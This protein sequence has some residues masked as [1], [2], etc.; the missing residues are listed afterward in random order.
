MIKFKEVEPPN[1]ATR[2]QSSPN[3]EMKN[4]KII[5]KNRKINKKLHHK[6]SD[7]WIISRKCLI[8]FFYI[9]SFFSAHFFLPFFFLFYC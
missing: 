5:V 7:N 8:N 2:M 3:M 1:N 4:N 9:L 6:I